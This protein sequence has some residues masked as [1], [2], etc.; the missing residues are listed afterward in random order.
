MVE[1]EQMPPG[2]PVPRPGAGPP[3]ESLPASSEAGQQDGAGVSLRADTEPESAPTPTSPAGLLEEIRS[4]VKDRLAYDETKERMFQELYV[5][6]QGFKG[7]FLES[8]QG[9]ARKALVSLFDS[10]VRMERATREETSCP[11]RVRAEAE[12]LRVEVEEAL[13]RLDVVPFA[14]HPDRLDRKLHKTVKVVETDSPEE[15]NLVVEVVRTGFLHKDVVL[16]PEEVV[17]KRFRQQKG[18]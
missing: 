6:L 12:T 4:L 10:V 16:R 8:I 15:D 2:G 11:E 13:Y 3:E 17:V 14:E 5:Q 1:E 7:G 9:Q 18:G